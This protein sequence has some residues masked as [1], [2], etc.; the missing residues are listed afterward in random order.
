MPTDPARGNGSRND[1]ER[2]A[3]RTVLALANTRIIAAA[4]ERP[5]LTAW[6]RH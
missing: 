1:R 3:L 6:E 5:E 4:Q 2:A